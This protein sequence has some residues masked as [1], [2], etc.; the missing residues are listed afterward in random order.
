MKWKSAL[1]VLCML[2]LLAGCSTVAPQFSGTVAAFDGSTMELNTEDGQITLVM[3]ENVG[4]VPGRY[5]G[6]EEILPGMQVKVL[7]GDYKENGLP[8]AKK[9]Y[10]LNENTMAAIGGESPFTVETPEGIG[11]VV[12]E[13]TVTPA[14]VHFVLTNYTQDELTYGSDYYV[15]KKVDGVWHSLQ[16][17]FE[18]IGFTAEGYALGKGSE[19]TKQIAWTVELGVLSPGEYRIVKSAMV[20]RGTGDYTKYWLAAEFTVE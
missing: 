4:L 11:F 14:S 19:V 6:P 9:I 12:P 1:A 5:T 7:C 16:Y 8:M 13:D 20:F 2:C 17:K 10:V 3:G 15:E 18:N